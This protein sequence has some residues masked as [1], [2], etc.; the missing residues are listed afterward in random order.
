TAGPPDQAQPTAGEPDHAQP[1]PEQPETPPAAAPAPPPAF[2]PPPPAAAPAPVASLAAAG[3]VPVRF[4][5]AYRPFAAEENEPS[6]SLF[7]YLDGRLLTGSKPAMISLTTRSWE[8][9]RGLSPGHHVIRLVQERHER[10]FGSDRW[11]HAS[12]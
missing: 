8:L 12:R 4:Q 3:T 10:R 6:W 7:V 5:L 9:D 1:A 2:P 11:Q